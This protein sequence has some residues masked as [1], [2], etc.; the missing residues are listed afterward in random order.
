MVSSWLDIERGA[1]IAG[2]RNY[3]LLGD[4]CLLEGAIL[5]LAQDRM[6]ARGFT[7]G[8]LDSYALAYFPLVAGLFL[9]SPL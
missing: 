2:S 1:R 8:L 6:V 9:K 4:L 3:I 5:R 7:V